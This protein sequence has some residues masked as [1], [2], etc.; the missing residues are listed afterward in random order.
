MVDLLK[1]GKK[2]AC[3]NSSHKFNILSI[4]R[5]ETATNTVNIEYRSPCENSYIV[6][7]HHVRS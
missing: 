4:E 1:D 5:L 2:L 6:P 7:P 3:G